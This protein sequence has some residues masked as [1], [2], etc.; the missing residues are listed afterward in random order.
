MYEK[1]E[2][3]ASEHQQLTD[4]LSKQMEMAI[5]EITPKRPLLALENDLMVRLR[6]LRQQRSTRKKLGVGVGVTTGAGVAVDSW[7]GVEWMEM[8]EGLMVWIWKSMGLAAS[9]LIP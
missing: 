4:W 3:Q 9:L 5:K 6:V 8:I 1:N 2:D 7:L